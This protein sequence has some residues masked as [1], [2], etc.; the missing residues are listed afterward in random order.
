MKDDLPIGWTRVSPDDVA[1]TERYS[2]AIGP[3]G[4]NLKVSDYRADGVPLIFVR[5]VRSARFDNEGPF[6]SVDKAAELSAHA[7]R[8]GDI[9]VTKMGE[10][11]GDSTMYPLGRPPGIITADCIKWSVDSQVGLAQF[12]EYALHALDVKRQ[13]AGI[14]Q[15]VAQRKISLERFRTLKVPCAPLHE[16]A[17]IVEALDSFCSRLDAAVATLEAAQTKLKAYRASVLKAAVEGRLVPTEATLA[18]AEKR[19]FEPADV[20][21]R[22]ILSDRR[23]RWEQAELA[24]LK[25][26]GKSPKDD[27]W[28]AKY[29]EPKPPDTKELPELPEGWRW[30]T[31]EQLTAEVFYGTSAKAA[32]EGEVP[33]LRMGNLADG[34][35]DLTRLKFLPRH[36][37][38]FPALLLQPSDILFNRTNSAELVGK[39]AVYKGR[40]APC[41][42]A[43]YLI[44]ARPLAEVESQWL[45]HTLN[46]TYGR[47]WVSSVVVQQ[48]GQANVNG[49]K[50]K[51][52]AVPLPPAAE[53]SRLLAMI[54]THFS[55]VD[56]VTRTLAREVRR[57]RRLTQAI[58]KWAFEGKLV[59]Q[60]PNDEQAN[61]LLERIRAERANEEMPKRIRRAGNA[62]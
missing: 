11:P 49:S 23:R 20:L 19:D 38:E 37:P 21:L 47:F 56:A 10:P 3:F 29:E 25:A 24:K 50:L 15:G 35:L 6:V 2:L 14:T 45:A 31:V 17:R 43:S 48:V 40:P 55:N 41:S 57:G 51:A 42:F 12:F 30:A 16:Q 1:T 27:V 32:P 13:I 26:A 22:R 18:R 33:V 60:D 59:D 34:E 36:H 9:L 28:K 39:T 62:R 44:C 4:S 61:K 53:Q 7:V 5:H 54:E 8:P 46:S 52:F 58:L